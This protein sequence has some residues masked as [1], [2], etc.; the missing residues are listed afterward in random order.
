M[1][2]KTLK[3]ISIQAEWVAQSAEQAIEHEFEKDEMEKR[4]RN[5]F[6]KLETLML[7]D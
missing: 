4:M 1:T 6:D 7:E 5:Y 2:N 3:Q